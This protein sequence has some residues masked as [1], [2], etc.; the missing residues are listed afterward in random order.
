MGEKFVG[1]FILTRVAQTELVTKR[2]CV[3]HR[4]KKSISVVDRFHGV[5][6]RAKQAYRDGEKSKNALKFLHKALPPFQ[7]TRKNGRL[8]HSNKNGGTGFQFLKNN[9]P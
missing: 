6:Q 7:N 3:T 9:A 4:N 8:H 2:L 5:E 1:F